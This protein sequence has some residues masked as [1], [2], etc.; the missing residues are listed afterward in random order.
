MPVL[1]TV[2]KHKL[3]FKTCLLGLQQCFAKIAVLCEITLLASSSLELKQFYPLD[4]YKLLHLRKSF[5]LY[6][7]RNTASPQRKAANIFYKY[8]HTRKAF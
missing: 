2:F 1:Q 8:K 6:W 3:K 7:Q 5:K 4:Q